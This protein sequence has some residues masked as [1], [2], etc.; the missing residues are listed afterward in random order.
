MTWPLQDAKNR[1][2]ELVQCARNVGPQVVTLRGTPAA[3]VVSYDEYQR[4]TG[5][6][7]SL[8]QF[9]LDGDPWTDEVADLVNERSK[10][11]AR[12]IDF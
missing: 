6:R 8:A 10:K 4:L 1:F 2:S 12:D 9:L 11:P 3:V 5:A 7:P